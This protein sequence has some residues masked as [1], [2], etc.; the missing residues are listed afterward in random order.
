M[1]AAGS[2]LP[3]RFDRGGADRA[4]V[5]LAA[6]DSFGQYLFAIFRALVWPALLVYKGFEGIVG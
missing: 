2:G 3:G 4:G 5:L 6:S 1:G